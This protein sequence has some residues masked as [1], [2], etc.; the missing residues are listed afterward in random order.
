MLF[1]LFFIF[2][3]STNS[4]AQLSTS[5]SLESTGMFNGVNAEAT[6]SISGA[7]VLNFPNNPNI[8]PKINFNTGCATEVEIAIQVCNV[9]ESGTIDFSF[10]ARWFTFV[11]SEDFT[12][13]GGPLGQ[14][15]LL[16]FTANFAPTFFD[17]ITNTSECETKTITIA[18]IPGV[19]DQMP[20]TNGD[21]MN[22]SVNSLSNTNVALGFP[23]MVVTQANPV[24]ANGTTT[25][26]SDIVGFI[27]NPPFGIIT[28]GRFPDVD[29]ACEGANSVSYA[30]SGELVIDI[31]YCFNNTK[32]F[33]QPG[34]S[35]RIIDES[36]L[37]INKR[38][39]DEQ[40]PEFAPCGAMWEGIILEDGA[41]AINGA[42]ISGA[43]SAVTVMPDSNSV[44]V[45]NSDFEDNFIGVHFAD[46]DNS[47]STNDAEV[48]GFF[49]NTFRGTGELPPLYPGQTLPF[50]NANDLPYAGVLAE[51]YSDLPLF[52]TRFPTD[53]TPTRYSNMN[54]GIRFI[55]TSLNSSFSVFEDISNVAISGISNDGSDVLKHFGLND[56]PSLSNSEQVDF[57][58]CRNAIALTNMNA[59]IE[60]S[61]FLDIQGRGLQFFNCKEKTV[62]VR[63][64]RVSVAGRGQSVLSFFSHPLVGKIE[65]NYFVPTNIDTGT[66]I[67][68]F[69]GF[70]SSNTN[71]PGN[72]GN[73]WRINRNNFDGSQGGRT[74]I[75][76]FGGTDFEIKENT[77]TRSGYIS[78]INKYGIRLTNSSFPELDCNDISVNGPN[79]G[80]DIG[81]MIKA[82][83]EGEYECNYVDNFVN[84]IQFENDNLSN[85]FRGNTMSNGNQGL[86]F[87]S[88]AI[89]GKQGHKGNCWENN[90][91][92]DLS[93]ASP[94]AEFVNESLFTIRCIT[95]SNDNACGCDAKVDVQTIF[96]VTEEDLL[97]PQP[98]GNTESC[99]GED[100]DNDDDDD[101]I[102]FCSPKKF[103][104][105][106]PIEPTVLSDR[107]NSVV[108]T[109]DNANSL[110]WMSQFNVLRAIDD[111]MFTAINQENE[112]INL[113]SQSTELDNHLLFWS[114]IS[115][116]NVGAE[117]NITLTEIFSN[118]HQVRLALAQSTNESEQTALRS[119][120]D[121]LR[122]EFE[123]Q[124]VIGGS[125]YQASRE[126]LENIYS[127]Y[128]FNESSN[129]L[130]LQYMAF[131]SN[132]YTEYMLNNS[133]ELDSN[134]E[135]L[136]HTVGTTC[137][138]IAGP[139]SNIAKALY[140]VVSDGVVLETE[141]CE[142]VI[143]ER[144]SS[145]ENLKTMKIYPNPSTGVISI[146]LKESSNV[147]II[148][149]MGVVLRS[150]KLD[151]G[152]HSLELD[153]P[154]G[155][156]FVRDGKSFNEKL[157]ITK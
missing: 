135:D 70:S 92:Y 146:N 47:T 121:Q 76:V 130:H 31:D 143:G 46:T 122:L 20:D 63:K 132:L 148:N 152:T 118:I 15:D 112:I 145:K 104:P 154:S 156:Y 72:P 77:I 25:I 49:G 82:S 89:I 62:T 37:V 4:V 155:V 129:E 127:S 115:A 28:Q 151:R 42:I 17:P 147:D 50:F 107:L 136:L 27:Q 85:L 157:L 150:Y 73:S 19:F 13:V 61:H 119:Q 43:E 54:R 40:N 48:L 79:H 24:E 98:F 91:T 71:I 36:F 124:K 6:V 84:N 88:T 95:D 12:F 140:F 51:N 35:I 86:V 103:I 21:L 101:E 74:A 114:D 1:C 9:E 100:D 57:S 26:L 52:G 105:G 149:Q 7:E 68:C 116:N 96:N 141:D 58:R 106:T 2:F 16:T 53:L 39:G 123:N 38:A 110:H 78:G 87:S 131:V 56:D 41:L 120:L 60:D 142:S 137:L 93:H 44:L 66:D 32:F 138:D 33:M 134:Q 67:L 128:T 153:L 22:A 133:L 81:I 55:N 45:T 18:V 99:G 97:F 5:T 29:S 59:E 30:I 34:S 111:G 90:S 14:N 75:E 125:I 3:N 64:N 8:A 144:S 23:P 113:R 83:I 126:A 94:N 11:E 102:A 117:E 108:Y 69:E 109:N 80:E 10:N 139:A 65:N